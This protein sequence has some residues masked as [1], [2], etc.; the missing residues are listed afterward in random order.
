MYVG[1]I[2]CAFTSR[3]NIVFGACVKF[4]IFSVTLKYS[5]DLLSI[6]FYK[7]FTNSSAAILT[8]KT[9][10]ITVFR[11]ILAFVF[12]NKV[13]VQFVK[14]GW[15]WLCKGY[16]CASE[17]RIRNSFSYGLKRLLFYHC[18]FSNNKDTC[19]ENFRVSDILI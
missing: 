10:C 2:P 13:G 18:I 16:N 6:S 11:V 9:L 8:N 17:G 5:F 4:Q 3:C 14:R 19:T 15:G 7:T 12:G 1:P